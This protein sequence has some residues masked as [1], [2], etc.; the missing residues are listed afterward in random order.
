MRLNLRQIEAFRAVYRTGGMTA[1][2]KL[3]NITQPAVSR[4]IR[5]LET[6]IGLP[7]FVRE[8]TSIAPTADATALYHEVEKSFHGL[9]Q[10]ALFASDLKR[11][12]SGRI[13]IAASLA[14]S[15]FTIPDAIAGFREDW[16]DVTVSLQSYPSPEVAEL[17]AANKADLGLAVLPP[18][19]DGVEIMSLPALFVVAV[20]P[21]KHRLAKY[22][23]IR[24]KDLD[25]EAMLMVNEYSLMQQ[26]ILK[27]FETA[28]I[29]P[30]VIFDSSYSGSICGL[31]AK[32]V[33][34]SVLDPVTAR[35]YDGKGIVRV[36]FEPQVPYELRLIRAANRPASAHVR[37]F[38][39]AL[40]KTLGEN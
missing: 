20:V 16:P 12:R 31:V 3:M 5:D 26:R 18:Q 38:A 15:F 8:G 33:G 14:P 32:G 34:V 13:N 21:E 27:S 2:G 22:D 29:I 24:P 11:N 25:G 30:D 19:I 39:E 10:V 17:V 1:A 40:R 7:L 4:L 35:A 28:G 36:A 6:E 9:D 37:A 23:V